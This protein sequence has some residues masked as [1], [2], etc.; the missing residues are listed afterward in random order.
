[1]TDYGWCNL[2][3]PAARIPMEDLFVHLRVE[4]DFDEEPE[5]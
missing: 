2:C 1:M 3:K 5:K 4:H